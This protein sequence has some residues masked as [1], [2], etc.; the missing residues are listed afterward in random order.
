MR[1]QSSLT[2]CSCSN[3]F[4]SSALGATPANAFI[5]ALADAAHVCQCWAE[6]SSFQLLM[7]RQLSHNALPNLY[8]QRF[9]LVEQGAAVCSRYV[10]VYQL[11]ILAWQTAY[12]VWSLLLPSRFGTLVS[13]VTIKGW[14][15]GVQSAGR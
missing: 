13:I 15:A 1:Q 9:A 12:L 11:V 10:S 14:D 3:C 5:E 4:V 6:R 2:S 7:S 8:V